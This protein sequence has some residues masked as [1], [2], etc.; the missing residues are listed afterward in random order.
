[1]TIKVFVSGQSNAIGRCTGGPDWSGISSDVRVW[2]NVNPLGA[3][4]TSFVSA[5]DARTAGTFQDTD[6][7]NFGVWF[8]DR[9]AREFLEPVDLTM[10][11]R[12]ASPIAL[13]S[14]DEVTFPILDQC[15]DVW[16]ET[17]QGP[18]DI[19][20]W[21]QGES[22]VIAADFAGW[23]AAFEELVTN[24]TTRGVISDQALILIGGLPNS[25][26]EKV[27]F[28]AS[29][30]MPAAKKQ[31]RAFVGADGLELCDGTHFD[32]QSLFEF[33]AWRYWAAY[34]FLRAING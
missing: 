34:L 20:L 24:L 8:C 29:A 27:N 33:G 2:D 12:G 25:I 4:G 13:W 18:A 17:G 21:H 7:N 15:S 3:L 16:A 10:V 26:I 30:L 28:N 5:E 9:L 6:R 22:D 19:F 1:M 32:G 11:A 23:I 14:P 31:R